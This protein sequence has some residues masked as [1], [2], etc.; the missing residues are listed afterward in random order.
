MKMSKIMV[1]VIGF[2]L[3]LNLNFAAISVTSPSSAEDVKAAEEY[4]T[5]VFQDPIDM[6]EESD[7]GFFTYDVVTGSKS[8][9]SNIS[10]TGGIFSATSSTSDPQITILE[11]GQTGTCFLGKIGTNYK[12][13]ADKYKIFVARMKLSKSGAGYFFWSRNTIYNDQS[14]T[15]SYINTFSEW[16]FYIINIPNLGWTKIKS[17]GYSYSGEIDSLRFDPISSSATTIQVDWFRLVELDNSLYRTIQWTGSTG[18]VDIYLDNDQDEG[19]GTLGKL[20]R[21]VSGTSYQFYTGALAP[22]SY[23]V[24]IKSATG[25][26]MVYSN[27]YYRVND[28]PYMTFT[29]P[30]VEGGDDFATVELGNAW[31]MNATSDLDLYQNLS[32]APSIVTKGAV[33]RT[34]KSI[35]SIKVLKGTN[36]SGSSD[37]IL[38][39]LWFDG[40]RGATTPIN[41]SKYR[42]LVLKMGLPGSWD[43]VG[44]SE[45]R[46][47]WHVQGEFSGG[48]ELMHQSADIVIRHTNEGSN[49]MMDTIITDMNTIKLE[50]SQSN[51]GWKG[52]IDGFRLDPH[53]FTAAKDFYIQKI[54]LAAFERA[55][56][57]YVF[58]WNYT[59]SYS[60]S[61]AL[62]L[63]YDTNKTGYDG[64]LIVAGLDPAAGTYTW[65][66]SGMAEGTYYI[67]A[68][69]NDGINSNRT[70]AR[71]PIVIDHAAV[72]SPAISLNKT[73]LSFTTSGSQTF[74]VSN[75]GGGTLNWTV[76][77]NKFWI[78]VNPASGTNS[79]TVTVTV[80]K[81][82]LTTG[83]YTGLVTVSSANA[84]NSPQTIDVTL[85]IGGSGGTP[86]ISLNRSALY[87]G[88]SGSK[89]TSPQWITVNNTGTGTLNWTA[90]DN[91]AWLTISPA[92]GGSGSSFK[93]T[94]NKSGLSTGTYKGEIT[95]SAANASNSPRKV[96]VTLKIYSSGSTVEPIGTFATPL[97]GAKVAG[98]IAVTG[99]AVDDIEVKEVKIYSGSTAIDNAI[100]VEDAR[101]DV[102]A[103]YPAYPRS[104]AAGWGYMLLTNY[105]PGGGNGTYTLSAVATDAEGYSV[106][107]GS[108]TIKVDNAHAKKPFGAIDT[109]AQGGVASGSKFVNWGWALT[110]LPNK[111]ATNG[112]TLKVYVDGVKIGNPVY[113]LYREDIEGYFPGYANAKGASGYYV[114][115]T[116]KYANGLHTIEWNA[117]DN[118]GNN[119]GIGSRF[120]NIQNTGSSRSNGVNSEI[121]GLNGDDN[122]SHL[123]RIFPPIS[124]EQLDILPMNCLDTVLV[125]K[126]VDETAGPLLIYPDE[127]G[128]RTVSIRELERLVIYLENYPGISTNDHELPSFSPS[129]FHD[130]QTGMAGYLK[131]VDE[132]RPLPLGS[133][134]DTVRGIFYWGPGP[135]FVGTYD[136]IFM[137]GERRL[138]IRVHIVSQY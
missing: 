93:V 5:S 113:N 27:G 132:Y 41:A 70:Y 121:H 19:N 91:A 102:A 1:F 56:T 92:S 23:Y 25:G 74:T 67:Y 71:W 103:A 20:A 85:T 64:T 8:N 76:S 60:T 72:E 77:D 106:S 40:G 9:L 116:T 4:G 100:F 18:N 17:N 127:R 21:S 107:L 35:G 6:N 138:D 42:I 53:E 44:G 96:T 36:K 52:M 124:Q 101:P 134:L 10:L 110:P 94:A 75:S 7:L 68:L 61:P 99:W 135:G 80:D 120:F 126:G 58:H 59:D 95:V 57:Q 3:L 88:A 105:L 30:S 39:P 12:I 13:N 82:G 123:K 98:S 112:S 73:A 32:G 43:P 128:I 108:A 63:Y 89:I 69:M 87:F 115:N 122:L 84:T 26:A 2:A 31:D 137:N 24:G 62:A 90:S 48:V 22:G 131:A 33:D 111:I 34:G 14:T 129:G 51:T 47:F 54:K 66:T 16:H 118:A 55:D 11:S 117:T 133:S 119:D 104:Y 45:A 49:V 136:L 79:G 37:P 46:V 38:Y 65:D 97:E 81:T 50:Q 15:N 83:T 78:T 86:K 28:I 125:V 29:S 130:G 114:L 109:P